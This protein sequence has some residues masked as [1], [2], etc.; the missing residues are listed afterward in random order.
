MKIEHAQVDIATVSG[1]SIGKDFFGEIP[2]A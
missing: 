2:S 1:F